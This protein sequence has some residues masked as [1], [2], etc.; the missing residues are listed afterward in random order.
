VQPGQSVA[1]GE[2]DLGPGPFYLAEVRIGLA[3]LTGYRQELTVTFDGTRD[4]QPQQWTKS[5][6]FQHNQSPPESLMSVEVTGDADVPDPVAMAEATGASYA[7]RADG[8]CQ[9]TQ[10]D[11]ESPAALASLLPALMGADE[12][13]SASIDGVE[14]RHYTFDERAMAEA[15]RVTTT[16]EIWV[17]TEGG[18]VVRFTRTTHGDAGYFG[19]GTDGTVTWDY[20][21]S[22]IGQPQEIVLPSSCRLDVP[23]MPDATNT[24]VLPRWAGF[25]TSS[26]ASDAAGFYGEQLPVGGWAQQ[27]ETISDSGLEV[28][29]FARDDE[30]LTVMVTTRDTGTHVDLV[31]GNAE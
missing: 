31:L 15:G 23:I 3:D 6:V 24:L 16:G 29:T 30:V 8:T 19:G 14:A 12:A 17:A 10:L 7:A 21:L 20:Q 25:D 13:G 26:S 22:G 11:V 2:I 27:G 28:R 5:Y 18:Y 1:P 9:G 4:G